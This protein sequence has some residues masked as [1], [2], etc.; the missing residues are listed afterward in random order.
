MVGMEFDTAVDGTP[1]VLTVLE[2]DGDNVK[3]DANHPLAGMSLFFEVKVLEIRT[4]EG[5][6]LI[7][8]FPAP[9]D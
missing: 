7:Q 4:G 5:S 2:V 8:G 6:E 1:Y 9:N 3:V